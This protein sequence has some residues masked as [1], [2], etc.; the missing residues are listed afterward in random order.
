MTEPLA[1]EL[2][3][4]AAAEVEAAF[5]WYRERSERAAEGFLRELEHALGQVAA[6]PDRWLLYGPG[7]RGFKLRRYPFAVIYR[8]AESPV[9]IIAIAHGRRRPGYW[10][11]R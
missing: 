7:I 9:Q 2:H 4:E 1:P 10:R 3:P 11:K 8:G 6:F 5:T